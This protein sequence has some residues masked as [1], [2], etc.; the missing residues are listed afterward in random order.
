MDAIRPRGMPPARVL[1]GQ[2]VRIW[3]GFLQA[4][5]E[6]LDPLCE[7]LKALLDLLRGLRQS[8]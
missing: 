7:H 5:L 4:L 6:F 1:H 2:H 8:L 3:F